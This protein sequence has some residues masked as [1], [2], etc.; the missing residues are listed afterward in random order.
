MT[1]RALIWSCKQGMSLLF[2]KGLDVLN[3][4]KV[5]KKYLFVTCA[6]TSVMAASQVNAD[7]WTKTVDVSSKAEYVDNPR[8]TTS[9]DGHNATLEVETTGSLQYT[10]D[11]YQLEF[12]GEVT[13]VKSK[14]QLIQKDYGRYK[15]GTAGT[16]FLES[17]SLNAGANLDIDSVMNTE[18]DDSNVFISNVEK[19][20]TRANAGGAFSLSETVN[21][22]VN[23]QLTTV[24]FDGGTYVPYMQAGS[25]LQTV[26]QW[27]E[28][29][30]ITSA[31]DYSYYK[32]RTSGTKAR[33]TYGFNLGTDI[34][35][36][37]TDNLSTTLGVQQSVGGVGWTLGFN[38]QQDWE[39]LD[40]NVGAT[41][42]VTPSSSGGLTVNN[43][44]QADGSYALFEDISLGARGSF[45]TTEVAATTSSGTSYSV[46]A[47]PFVDWQF[48][49][50]WSTRLSYGERMQK[51]ANANEWAV[52]RTVYLTLDYRFYNE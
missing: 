4:R 21:L 2:H 23:N 19:R 38:Y 6:L 36:S 40:L 28:D 15:L 25:S 27:S 29:I 24:H 14:D 39:Y 8:M 12:N 30:G 45:R 13:G 44:L 48:A 11:L 9:G 16:L 51:G 43:S 1:G 26:Y 3:M 34:A 20:T 35:L 47:N 50:D 18:F 52:S 49:E 33:H 5:S 46:S 42:G 41:R 7:A 31:V 10:A 32:T 17:G 22:N 37:D